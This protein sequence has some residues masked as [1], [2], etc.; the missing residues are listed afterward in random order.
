MQ[1]GG[2]MSEESKRK[3]IGI[4]R[5]TETRRKMSIAQT[6]RHTSEETKRKLSEANT[7]K[8]HPM[9]R[10]H[11]GK[12]TRRKIGLRMKGRKFSEEWRRKIG[13]AALGRYVSKETRLKMSLARPNCHHSSETRRKISESNK[14]KNSGKHWSE[15]QCKKIVESHR[16]EKSHFWRGGRMKNYPEKEQIRKSIEYGFWRKAIYERDN[17]TCQSCN[18]RGGKLVAHHLNNFADFPELRFALDNGI[19]LCKKC[20]LLFHT[21]Y[22]TQNNTKE[23]WKEY[24]E[25]KMKVG[26]KS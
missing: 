10:K 23:Q 21:I 19:T 17:F 14:G 4:V 20:H 12:E 5:S 3:M 15:E 6:G 26:E 16:G 1:K 18:Q 24:F 11:H 8:K 2:H 9:F 22:S 13:I 7:G 25:A